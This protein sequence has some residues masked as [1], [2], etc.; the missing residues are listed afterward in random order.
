MKKTHLF[1]ISSA[2]C[3][4][5]ALIS[6]NSC[7]KSSENNVENEGVT[8][9]GSAQ[10]A[11]PVPVCGKS[12]DGL[13]DFI[14]TPRHSANSRELFVRQDEITGRGD[15]SYENP[16]G[17]LQTAF[18]YA[19]PG[20]TIY[21]LEG[22]YYGRTTVST[23]GEEDNWITVMPYK[24]AKVVFDGDFIGPNEGTCIKVLATSKYILFKGFEI[25]NYD[26]A[27]IW[28]VGNSQYIYIEDMEIHDIST[29]AFTPYG[30]EA[31][32]GSGQ[33]FLIRDCC[34]YDIGKDRLSASDH[35]IYMLEAKNWVVDSNLFRT[36]PGGGIHQFMG[37]QDKVWASNIYVTN[38][39]FA[40]NL[41]HI[42]LSSCGNF[43]IKNNIFI[44][45]KETDFYILN[46]VSDTY[47]SDNIFYNSYTKDSVYEKG[48]WCADTIRPNRVKSYFIF[49]DDPEG[50]REN[51]FEKNLVMYESMP[52]RIKYGGNLYARLSGPDD[53]GQKDSFNTYSDNIFV[54]PE[55]PLPELIKSTVITAVTIINCLNH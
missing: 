27:G 28:T 41:Y 10:T 13:P 34:F 20:D 53:I 21:L 36:A 40:E 49:S 3:V 45:A 47:I 1:I 35:G 8:K 25:K 55:L 11:E 52:F 16:Y 37:Y 30:T 4:L 42:V 32:L 38:N 54:K 43:Y 39:I 6:L 19:L 26:G 29:P 46:H 9:T 44:N 18:K 12:Y 31:I 51:I 15:G 48:T 17:C 24:D 2:F 33:N 5:L 50:F 14:I 22:T 7:S 23:A